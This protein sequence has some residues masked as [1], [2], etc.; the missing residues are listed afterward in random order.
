MTACAQVDGTGLCECFAYDDDGPAVC[1]E[2][3]VDGMSMFAP[4][5]E[6]LSCDEVSL[7]CLGGCIEDCF[8]SDDFLGG[9]T[10]NTQQCECLATDCYDSPDCTDSDVILI[11]GF[12]EGGCDTSGEYYYGSSGNYYYDNWYVP[13]R[14][15]APPP[16]PLPPAHAVP[17]SRRYYDDPGYYWGSSNYYMGYYDGYE[18]YTNYYQPQVRPPSPPLRPPPRRR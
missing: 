16:P 14:R 6:L 3:A 15:S 12:V 2:E 11:E 18:Y 5:A 13:E 17:P 9:D 10:W 8:G 4:N 7:K 1:H